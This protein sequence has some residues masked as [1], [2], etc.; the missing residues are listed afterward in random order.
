MVAIVIVTYNTSN[1]LAKQV[2][3]LK[4]F[5]KDE[6]EIIVVDN[7][8]DPKKIEDIEY[9]CTQSGVQRIK[10]KSTE[11]RG[12]KSNAFAC[13]TAY[14]LLR[15]KYPFF[16][17]TDHDTF[18]IRDFSVVKILEGRAI[19]GIGQ[20]KS[21]MYFQQ[22]SLMWDNKTV[23]NNLMDFSTN[24]E[25]GLDTGGNLYRVIEQVTRDGCIFFNE[26]YYQN[27][28]FNQTPY[29]FYSTINDDM[30][31]HFINGSGWNPISNNEERIN[32]LLAILEERIN[33][34]EGL[35]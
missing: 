11:A 4:R 14:A 13:N 34:K 6:Y 23:D 26:K 24:Q 10:V 18:A 22:T 19:A 27:P 12:S 2:E 15:D 30:F 32:T 20:Q 31:M 9:L 8:N 5:C 17:Y 7:S 35:S 25:F 21:R 29:N 3:C 28:Y 16:Y 1:L 33:G